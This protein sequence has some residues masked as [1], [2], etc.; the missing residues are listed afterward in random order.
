[1]RTYQIG[2]EYRD[3]DEGFVDV[4][5]YRNIEEVVRE[6]EDSIRSCDNIRE[7]Q[8]FTV[9]RLG[10]TMRRVVDRNGVRKVLVH[11]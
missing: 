10:T 9:S 5:R 11:F 6:A 8:I 2:I 7:I 3:S 4:D 1:M